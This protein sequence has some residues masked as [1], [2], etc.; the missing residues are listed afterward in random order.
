VTCYADADAS[1]NDPVA[2]RLRAAADQWHAT[3]RLDDAALAELIREHRVDLLVDITLHMTGSRLLAFARRP[4]PVQMTFIGYPATTGLPAIDYRIT[5]PWLDPPGPASDAANVE[6]LVHLPRTFWCYDAGDEPPINDP[7]AATAGRVTFGS[8]NNPAKFSTPVIETWA[9]ILK[10]VPASALML[11]AN[12]RVD[13]GRRVRD[14]FAR[15]GVAPDRLSFLPRVPRAV[16]LRQYA[17]IDIALDPWPYNGHMTSCDALWMGV[18][19][20]SLI[21][22][23][24]VARAGLSILTSIGLQELLASSRQRYVEIAVD[25]AGDLPRLATLRRS[26][27]DRMRSSPL[28]DAKAFARDVETIYRELWKRWCVKSET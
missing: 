10:S 28:M 17:M 27:R 26:L 20:V 19:L 4:A 15:R 2:A 1:A 24:S 23:T 7:P 9:Q 18:P 16:Y 22:Q 8:L 13:P 5:D 14:E 12:E 21:G 11:F 6:R 25:L 3:A